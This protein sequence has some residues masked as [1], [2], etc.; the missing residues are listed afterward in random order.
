M[1]VSYK[2]IVELEDREREVL[3]QAK[4]IVIKLSDALALD[5]FDE[6]NFL[7]LISYLEDLIYGEEF[8]KE[9]HN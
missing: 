5:E 7:T 3:R 8:I 2:K 6:I 9:G 1:L 4:E